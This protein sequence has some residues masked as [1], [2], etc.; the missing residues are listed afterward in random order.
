M[1]VKQKGIAAQVSPEECDNSYQQVEDKR[2]LLRLGMK[3]ILEKIYNKR[4]E[5]DGEIIHQY[6]AAW[7]TTTTYDANGNQT[8]STI[9]IGRAHV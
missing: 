3:Q 5:Q 4:I 2:K 8:K 6:T 9:K 7:T 1:I